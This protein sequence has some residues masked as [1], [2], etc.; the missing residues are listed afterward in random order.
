MTSTYTHGNY[1]DWLWRRT[2]H[3]LSGSLSGKVRETVNA[4]ENGTGNLLYREYWLEGDTSPRVNYTYDGYGNVDTV[5]DARGNI[6]TTEYETILHTHPSR[7]IS[8]ATNGVS[9]ITRITSYDYRWGQP[10]TQIDENGNITTF[11]YDGLGRPVQ[12]DYPD[13]GQEVKV[14]DDSLV[15]RTV[16]TRVKES[17]SQNIETYQYFDGF[18]RPVQ[19][20]S[21]G[22]AGQPIVARQYYDVMGR[23]YLNR[24]PF[25]SAGAGYPQQPSGDHPY[26]QTTDYDYRS[27]PLRVESPLDPA[28]HSGGASVAATTFSYDGYESTITDADGSQKR[29]RRDYL[30]RIVR[31]FEYLDAQTYETAY[32]YNAAGDLAVVLNKVG[33]Q[34]DFGYDTMGRKT[35]MF[36]PDLGD[37]SYTYDENGN[38]KTQTDAKDQVITFDY[39][40]LN[41][42]TSKTY[43]SGDPTVTYT[44]DNTAAG[45]NGIGRLHEVSNAASTTT[46]DAYDEMGRELSVTKSIAG[47]PQAAYTTSYTYDPA[48]KPLTMNYPDGYQIHHTY[49]AG[50]GLLNTVTGPEPDFDLYAEL[51][52]YRPEGK[53]GSI[54]FGNG[55]ATSYGYDDQ[56]SRLTSIATIDPGLSTLLNKSY[57]YS[58]AGDVKTILDKDGITYTYTY[59]GLHR[60][61]S[62]TN[63]G[64][65]ESFAQVVVE[66]TYNDVF[67]PLHAPS[68]VR[69]NDIDYIY[70]YDANGNMTRMQN[71]NDPDNVREQDIAYNADNMP[72]QIEWSTVSSGSPLFY[73]VNFD[74]DGNSRRVKK[75][76]SW[77]YETYYV[78]DHFEI[79]SGAEI[80]YIFAGNQRVAKVTAAGT[81]FFHKDHLGSSNVVTDY[82]S[83]AAV[84][85][86][87]YMPFGQ[88]RDHSGTTISSYKFT[89]QEYDTATGLYNYDA[90]LYDPVVGRFI[91]PDSIVQNFFDPQ[92]LNRY[93]YVR[94]NPLAYTDPTGHFFQIFL[95]QA[96]STSANQMM[97]NQMAVSAG[98]HHYNQQSANEAIAGGL[99]KVLKSFDPRVQVMTWMNTLVA[100][101]E[102]TDDEIEGEPKTKTQ[103]KKDAKRKKKQEQ[104]KPNDPKATKDK[105]TKEKKKLYQKQKDDEHYQGKVKE[106]IDKKRFPAQDAKKRDQTIEIIINKKY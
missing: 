81:H 85:S 23:N 16:I 49:F 6:T 61:V 71:F 91:S 2:Q 26:E 12:T 65:A 54:Y 8:P 51:D 20:V 103:E 77:G 10:T 38:L 64:P 27:R 101:G 53:I 30:G 78:G 84:E 22:E 67:R 62:E 89:D 74:Y 43:S 14:Y 96:I 35:A 55:T 17:D 75:T 98:S 11:A 47:A 86:S 73:N 58:A 87:E 76:K 69:F 29:E 3:T 102:L 60:L 41:R 82:A 50:S 92:M 66:N 21:F 105:A 45:A 15:P 34:T 9:H 40:A 83:G 80:K 1:G 5:T 88:T 42:M 63:N 48:G 19:A 24:G 25:F 39:D 28:V 44:Y 59:D 32:G 18:G 104:S 79:D 72:K 46:Y 56:S 106:Q 37:W 4:Y 68:S 100:I 94:N 36:D 99:T 13:G 7:I 95:Q 93:S 70:P 90:R 97:A 57:T 52:S 31:V 33:I